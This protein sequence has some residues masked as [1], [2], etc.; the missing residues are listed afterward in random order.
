MDKIAPA[1]REQSA[2]LEQISTQSTAEQLK[3]IGSALRALRDAVILLNN[4]D[5]LE[6]W[7]QAA[8]DLLLLQP[9]DKGQNIFDFITVPEFRQY[10]EGT[11]IPND[12]VHIESWRDPSRYLKCELTPFGDEKLLF[13]YDVTRLRHLEQM[14]QDFVANVSHELRTPLTVMMG[15]LENFSDQP[16]MPPQW[17]RGFEL[18]TQQT[19]RMN[20]I[21]N[22]LLLLSKIEIEESHELH[23][24]DMTKLLTNIYDD[25]QAYNQAY[26]HIIHLHIDTY[27]GLYGSEMYLNSAL[28]NLVINAIKY[29]PKGGNITISWTRTSDGCRFAVEDDGIG[30]AS[31]HI[32]RLTER[33]YRIDKGRSR[34]TGGTGL[35]LAIVKHVLHQHEAQLQIDSVEGEGST[36]SVVF[37][38]NYVR[39]VTAN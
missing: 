15:Y 25:A 33:F 20:R 17:R 19:A 29:T 11:T 32:A 21:V 2:L 14:R 39:S 30:I 10:Y 31:E 27:D 36:F 6:W 3:K 8:Q 13:V 23:Y 4:N 26:K 35:G 5:G 38:S 24:I 34:A 18:M 12:G 28:S 1:Q 9:E 37:P 22:D 16:D 7:N